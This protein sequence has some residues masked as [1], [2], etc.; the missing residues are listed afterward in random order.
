MTETEFKQEAATARPKLISI[1]LRYLKS[2]DEAEDIVQDAM[3][4]LW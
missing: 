3:L 1:A 2:N 4:R